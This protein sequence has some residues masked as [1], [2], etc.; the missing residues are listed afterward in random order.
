MKNDVI[1]V[2][3]FIGPPIHNLRI[4]STGSKHSR[5]P[6]G[7]WTSDIAGATAPR[8]LRLF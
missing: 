7:V 1:A 6:T 3:L 5:S 8:T 2:L 4:E